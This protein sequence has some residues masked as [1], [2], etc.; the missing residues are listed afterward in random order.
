MCHGGDSQMIAGYDG[1]ACEISLFNATTRV[2]ANQSWPAA[3]DMETSEGINPT[4]VRA[5]AAVPI[6]VV[7]LLLWIVLRSGREDWRSEYAAAFQDLVRDAS[8]SLSDGHILHVPHL[9][10]VLQRCDK[11]STPHA[12]PK[13]ATNSE[14]ERR[15]AVLYATKLAPRADNHHKELVEEENALRAEY[16]KRK[17]PFDVAKRAWKAAHMSKQNALY[18]RAELLNRQVHP[19]Y[20]RG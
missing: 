17:R 20:L 4:E 7:L 18:S 16:D 10:H 3:A 1:K 12:L 8:S 6:V 15:T 11:S 19:P 2:G 14:V 9:P 13:E 5:L